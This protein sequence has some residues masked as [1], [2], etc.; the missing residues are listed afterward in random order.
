MNNMTQKNNETVLDP[1]GAT[2]A[3]LILRLWL[4]MR[5]LLT[6]IEKFSGK[7][8]E[9]IPTLINGEPDPNGLETTVVKKFYSLGNYQGVPDPLYQS[10]KQEPLIMEWMLDSYN[11]ILGPA[12]ILLG[13]GLLL[14]LATRISL[15]GM[16]LLYTSLTLGL[17]LLNQS[18]GIAWLATHIILVVLMLLVAQHNRLE[19]GSL[20]RRQIQLRRKTDQPQSSV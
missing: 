8:I 18:S 20:I 6:G 12:L 7:E 16:G 3:A 1:L 14:G 19:L 10:F 5:S 11:C 4:G 2:F 9:S 15:L 13:L 17:I